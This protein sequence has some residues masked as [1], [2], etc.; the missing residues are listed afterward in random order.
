M[1]YLKHVEEICSA[2][3]EMKEEPFPSDHTLA[4][5]VVS[6]RCVLID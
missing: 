2:W 5:A 4:V 1:H 6:Y 3:N